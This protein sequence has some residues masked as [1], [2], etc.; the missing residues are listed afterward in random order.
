[1]SIRKSPKRRGLR[2]NA[3][4]S[5]PWS[6]CSGM[7]SFCSFRPDFRPPTSGAP[8]NYCSSSVNGYPTSKTDHIPE[9]CHRSRL[10]GFEAW[11]SSY[12]TT[13][14]HSSQSI[15]KTT[16]CCTSDIHPGF[17]FPLYLDMDRHPPGS[18]LN[19]NSD[20]QLQVKG[21]ETITRKS[22]RKRTAFLAC[23]AGEQQTSHLG[24]PTKYM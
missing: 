15:R 3:A 23:H 9:R 10:R 24:L 16:S 14:E 1:M 19:L 5:E 20:S 18:P 17:M 2:E 7:M 6:S 22:Q 8:L 13:A 12:G 11:R 21:S 4:A